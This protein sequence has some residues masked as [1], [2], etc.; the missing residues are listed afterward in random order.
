[1]EYST[2]RFIVEVKN[3]KL[4]I[5]DIYQTKCY[6]DVFNAE[7]AI[8]ISSESLSREIREFI[9]EN[10]LAHRRLKDVIILKYIKRSSPSRDDNIIMEPKVLEEIYNNRLPE[11]L[12]TDTE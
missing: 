2:E 5:K 12:K 4:R 7:C 6:G 8:L 1:T 9:K 11:F 10:Y 3:R